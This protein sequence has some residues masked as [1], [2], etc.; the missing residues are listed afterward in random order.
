MEELPV[1][2]TTREIYIKL[3]ELSY[4]VDESRYVPISELALQTCQHMLKELLIAR[5]APRTTK[6]QFLI[7]A[8]AQAEIL[9]MQIRTIIELGV[10]DKENFLKLHSKLTEVRRMLGS[11][12]KSAH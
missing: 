11:W 3:L 4:A 1:I 5:H 6:A 7:Q 12:L 8:N 10:T 2:T 9:T